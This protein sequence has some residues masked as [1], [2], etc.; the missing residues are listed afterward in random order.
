MSNIKLCKN[1]LFL[2]TILSMLVAPAFS[3][4]PLP[5]DT[6]PPNLNVK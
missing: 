4:H 3:T 1:F 6:T 2:L 5:T